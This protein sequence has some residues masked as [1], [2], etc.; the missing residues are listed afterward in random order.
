M[1][2]RGKEQRY[3][4]GKCNDGS[5][6]VCQVAQQNQRLEELVQERTREL[7]ELKDAAD[8][9]NRAKSEFLAIMTHEI[10]TPLNGI[11]GMTELVLDMNMPREQ[12]EM[13]EVVLGSSRTLLSIVNDILDFS[14]IEAGRLELNPGPCVIRTALERVVQLLQ[15]RVYAKGLEVVVELAP[16]VPRSCITDSAR[17][18]QVFINL[19]SNAIKFS[20]DQGGVIIYVDVEDETDETVDLHFVVADAGVGIPE[21]KFGLIFESF[22]QADATVSRSYGG[23]GLGLAISARLVKLLGGKIWLKS[24]PEVGSAFHFMI[25]AEKSPEEIDELS[26]ATLELSSASADAIPHSRVL[27]VDD[28]EVNRILLERMLQSSGGFDTESA[29]DGYVA[30]DLIE[31]GD[32]DMLLVDLQMPLLDGWGL[33]ER[34]RSHKNPN[35]RALPIVAVSA[36][37]PQEMAGRVIQAGMNG[38]ISKPIQRTQLIEQVRQILK[39]PS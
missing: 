25:R 34:V 16:S 14:K 6:A 32:F 37:S 17:L 39:G 13:L 8:A 33:A 29:A 38:Y 35:V 10:R 15:A 36:H 2:K 9:A 7:V 23:T 20:N 28:S 24:K 19:I 22:T 31:H 5:C 26:D 30:L 27:V 3:C 4:G 11:L 18:A 12:R 1:T 21:D